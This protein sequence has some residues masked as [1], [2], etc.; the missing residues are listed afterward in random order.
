MTDA[1]DTAALDQGSWEVLRDRLRTRST[2]LAAKAERLNARRLEVYGGAEMSVVGNVRVRTENN[3]VPRDIAQVGEFLLFGYNVFLGLRSETRVE[4]VFSVHRFEE[5]EDGFAV[6][7]V[8]VAESFLADEAFRKDFAELYR[9]YKET[10]L[11]QLRRPEGRLLMVFA[12]GASTTQDLKVFRWEVSPD[13]KVRYVDNRGEREHV[14][15]PSHDFEWTRTGRDDFVLGRHPHVSIRDRVFVETVGGDLTIKV[16]DNTEDG[17]GIY[18]E[19]VDD[20]DQSLDDAEIRYAE[21]GGVILLEVL[22]YLEEKKRYFVF[23]PRRRKVHRVDAIGP[24]CRQLPEDHG[25]VFPGGIYLA[26]GRLRTFDGDFEGFELQ[27]MLRSP[28]GE[29]VAYLFHHRNDGRSV[30]LPYNLIAKDVGNPIHA[31]GISLFD[32]GRMVVF[33]AISDEATRV[34]PMQVWATP[35]TSDEHAAAQAP[36]DGGFVEKVGNPDLVRGISD[37]LSLARRVETEQLTSAIVED[38]HGAAG[39][40]LD[41]YWWLDEDGAEGL[42]ESVRGLREIAD[43]VAAEVE[44][45]EQMR[46]RARTAVR[47]AGT[48]LDAELRELAA[49]PGDSIADHVDGLARLRRHRGHLHSLREMRWIDGDAVDALEER[50]VSSI[51]EVGQK[52]VEHLL[53][54]EGLAP[55]RTEIDEL[56][57]KADAIATTAE[58]EPLRASLDSTGEGLETLVQVI[59]AL[60]IEDPNDRTAILESV[61]EVLGELNRARARLDA[62]RR[63]LAGK[64]G[65]AQL[66]AQLQLLAQAV[67]GALAIADSPESCDEQLSRLLLQVE[68]LESRYGE[69]D[70][71][72]DRLATRREEIVEAFSSRRQTLVDERQRRAER[73]V[74]AAERVLEGVVRRG[75]TFAEA[76]E[77]QAFFAGDPMVQKVRDLAARLRDELGDAVRADE[78]AAKLQTARNEAL[79]SQRDR[80]EIFEGGREILRLGRHRFSVETR[81]LEATL[82]PWRGKMAVHL[83]GTDYHDPVDDPEIEE[84][85]HLWDQVRVSETDD[86]YRGEFLAASIL[87]DAEEGK[88]DAGAGRLDMERL[89]QASLDPAELLGLVRS[90]AAER[91]DE[92]YERGVHD[93]DA[94]QILAT[95]LALHGS[96]DLLRFP[97]RP[98]ALAAVAWD[99]VGDERERERWTRRAASL[100]RLRTSF[101]SG[102]A[103]AQLA[104]ELGARVEEVLDEA[105][106]PRL[107]EDARLAGSYLA[108]ELSRSPIR[109][110]T[111]AEAAKLREAF[112]TH[113]RDHG[114]ARELSSDLETLAEVPDE[115]WRLVV[116]WLEA[117]LEDEG[118]PEKVVALRPALEETAALLMTGNR[119]ERRPSS[120]LHALGVEGLL[121]RHPRVVDRTMELRLDEMLA[122]LWSFRQERVPA[123]RAWQELRHRRIEVEKDRLRLGSLEP[124]VMS[125]FVRNRLIDEVYLPLVGDNL[126]KQIGSVGEGRR[127]DQMGLLLLVSPPGYGKTT[128]MEYVAN[129]LGLIFVKVDG[130]A[131]G[132]AVTSLDPS[133]APDAAA[134]QEV[135]KIGLALEMGNN[136]M[137]YLDDIQHTHPELLQKFISLC[138]AQRRIEG[139]WKGRPRS[140]DLRGKRFAVVMAGNP[141]TESGERFRIPD[142]LANRADVHNLGEVLTG[143]DTLFAD[144]YVENSLTSN[145]VL[146]P[147]AG[148][149]RE[150]LALLLRRARGEE[151]ATDQLSLG[152]SAAEIG[153]IVAV[154]AHLLKV[155][156]VTL[157]VNRQY[158][159]SAAQQ[160]AFRTEPRFQLQG[161]YRDF[162]KMAQRVVPVMDAAELEAVIDDHYRSESQTLT[163]G[164]EHN[165][166]KLAELRGRM[167]DAQ[168][169][170]W[171]EIKSKYR[172]VQTMGAADDDP[173]SRVVGQLGLLTDGLDTIGRSVATAAARAQEQAAANAGAPDPTAAL[174][175]WIEQLQQVLVALADASRKPAGA[176]LPDEETWTRLGSRLEAVANRLG[177]RLTEGLADPLA[178]LAARATP[179][180]A[181]A[182]PVPGS[183]EATPDRPAAAPDLA[184]YLDKL[185]STLRAVAEAPRGTQIVQALPAGVGELLERMTSSV[186]D[187]LLP[188]TQKVGRKLKKE[189]LEDRALVDLLDRSLKQ[190]DLLK[191]LVEALR[192]IDTRQLVGES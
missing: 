37:A 2:E 159:E 108:E 75:A 19:P 129:R 189:G 98:R 106:I 162:N 70:E 7:G 118:T 35:F 18:R 54:P 25:L 175:P 78:L 48:K 89:R 62:R 92:G 161:S 137:L 26:D 65:R 130:P 22:P 95:V 29:D 90:S 1:P 156:V 13:G 81:Q 101:G 102:R 63:E 33:R 150:D 153:E 140:Y 152:L 109:L 43:Q 14:Y 110:V 34:H 20:A 132:H 179:P 170:R 91:W 149:S 96:A 127:T 31:H 87:F 49:L 16:E 67:A 50:V 85:R 182:T 79:R 28:N 11:L 160:E 32:D 184:P 126:A 145:P 177:D 45:V 151:I 191:D 186:A 73:T 61:S 5:G 121:G 6:P 39:R 3:C 113:L 187:Q 158:I 112:E 40:M 178:E 57:T 174:G 119:L 173:V 180:P 155:R 154:L 128:L 192:K 144:S 12:T 133:A 190:L 107:P 134:R 157:M 51:E 163:T 68:E 188:L 168:R 142:M 72:A 80:A 115:R 30:V 53:E 171:N 9:Y 88:V 114:G 58:A 146:Q 66:G 135:E 165:L 69:I 21:V 185:D 94:A 56:G 52:A 23:D 44:K 60:R 17:L 143:K 71:M 181:P 131:L 42:A 123:F 116:A 41:A 10:R 120:A 167:T 59:D 124:R 24:S 55:W 104:R 77:L 97:P 82:V 176:G 105:G 8:A 169:E 64:E 147:L 83:T 47:D 46:E 172:R 76:D 86:V 4:D 36:L 148:A 122:R 138:D 103:M 125:A 15:P 166:L 183:G 136:V 84:F 27:R 74:Q 100:G 93:H 139:V 141:Y 117:F 164:A 99:L 38:L 111:S